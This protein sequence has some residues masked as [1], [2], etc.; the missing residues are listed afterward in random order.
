[1]NSF[2]FSFLWRLLAACCLLL[3][4]VILGGYLVSAGKLSRIHE[5]DVSRRLS[6]IVL[7]SGIITAACIYPLLLGL[8]KMIFRFADDVVTGNLDLA[9]SLGEAIALR[10]SDTGAHNFRVT[11]YAFYLAEA[12]EDPVIDMRTLMLGAFLHDIGKIGIH[13]AILLKPGRLTDDEM[14][15]M[16][17][18]V[19]LGLK[20]IK[21]SKWL[22]LAR[23]VIEG[24]HERF[25]GFGYPNGKYGKNIPIEARIFAIVD[26]FDAL[27]SERPYKGPIPFDQAILCIQNGAGSQFDPDLVSIFVS[28]ADRAYSTIHCATE[29]ELEEMMVDLVDRHRRVLYDARPVS[30]SEFKNQKV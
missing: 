21:S 19:E 3:I 27:T 23:N 10:D 26:V 17:T 22:Q 12:L 4:L 1:M 20:L 9:R 29:L 16:R 13:D 18:H 25:D 24:H 14:N 5:A 2:R 8:H 11:L 30:P 28:I 6:F 7:I 15:I